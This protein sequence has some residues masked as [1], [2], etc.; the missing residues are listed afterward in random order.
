MKTKIIIFSLFSILF[1]PLIVSA[2]DTVGIVSIKNA[3]RSF[4][5]VSVPNIR[6]PTVV[7]IPVDTKNV[8][9]LDYA[10]FNTQNQSFEPYFFKQENSDPLY[11]ISTDI[12]G[13]SGDALI[14]RNSKTFTEF[15]LP[16][17]IQ[18][19]V[20]IT[21]TTP[22]AITASSI[23]LLLDNNVA[24]PTSVEVRTGNE[25]K[26]ILARTK[27]E[28][29]TF[30]F[31]ETTS[32][33]WILTFTYNQLLRMS[34]LRIN[35]DTNTNQNQF[36]RFL[37]QPNNTYE[38]Y[39][40][41]DRVVTVP[42]SEGGNLVSPKDV[43]RI[44]VS[45]LQKNMQYIIADIDHDTIPDIKDNCTYVANTDQIDVNSNDRGDACDDFDQDGLINTADNC[46][47]N[48]N[49]NQSDTD[50]DKIGD[51]CDNAESRFTE[52]Y[53]WIPWVGIILALCVLMTFFVITVK[54][55]VINNKN[56]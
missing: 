13:L 44:P 48:P 37:A 55:T 56:N 33:K 30:Y 28:S 39:S 15:L 1:S 27:M 26:I 2:K 10:L 49:Q 23:T 54:S 9:R 29:T 14:D 18:G 51:V 52:K 34:E 43:M 36:I 3:Y 31:P 40:D 4:I 41:P 20:E 6:V 32:N 53:P 7:E 16:E 24:L 46:P 35:T 45:K 19:H 11:T 22:A 47:N 42:V 21:V 25:N 8:E 5:N 38:L 17:N 50:G 12:R